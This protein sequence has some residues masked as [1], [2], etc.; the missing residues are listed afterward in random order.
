VIAS[1]D[2]SLLCHAFASMLNIF[3]RRLRE[4]D[5]P[6]HLFMGLRTFED[7]DELY[8]QGRTK[9]GRIVT[10][11]RGGDSWHNY[12]LAADWVL[13]GDTE[14]PGIQWSWETRGLTGT[15]WHRMGELAE[16]CG[17]EWGGRWKRFPDLPH[18]QNRFGLR[19][20]DAKEL[21]HLGGIKQVW[22]ECR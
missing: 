20:A 3:E 16:S 11:A 14:K 7:Q 5:L 18:V 8:A 6:F 17:L 13:D 4:A 12:G 9:P 21:Y 10:N 22:Q 1:R 15:Q 19:L 2:K